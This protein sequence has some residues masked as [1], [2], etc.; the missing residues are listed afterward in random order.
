LQRLPP[1]V[2]RQ[3]H[4]GF[5]ESP[6][7]PQS[8]LHALQSRSFCGG[9]LR[10]RGDGAGVA[11]LGA[12][13]G[14]EALGGAGWVGGASLIGAVCVGAPC[15]IGGAV[16][17]GA[18]RA[19]G[20]SRAIDVDSVP[21]LRVAHATTSNA[22]QHDKRATFR[23]GDMS[24]LQRITVARHLTISA[25]S[26][27][28][29]PRTMLLSIV[30][31]GMSV[32]SERPPR[33]SMSSAPRIT[34]V[35]TTRVL[36]VDDDTEVREA[37]ADVLAANGYEAVKA[38]SGN[39]AL[40]LL[41]RDQT[42][43]LVL[44]DVNLPER[45]GFD[46]LRRL[47]ATDRHRDLPV[48]CVSARTAVEDKIA[49]LKLGA[50]D[51]LAKPFDVQELFA[52]MA[53]PLRVKRILERLDRARSA[54]EHLSLT[55]P[56]TG[57][58][59]RRDLEQ[60]LREEIDRSARRTEPLGCLMID[61]DRFKLVNDEFGHS[62]GDA[63]LSEVATVLRASIRSFDV[64][65]RFGGDEFVVLLPGATLEASRHVAE[66]LCDV[67]STLAIPIGSERT[68][69]LSISAGAVSHDP[70]TLEDAHALLDRA[71]AALL[72]A[73][74]TGRNRVVSNA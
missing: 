36:V 44:L 50:V 38:R 17:T 5:C 55:D 70:A 45:D 72:V 28:I 18:S 4:D 58:P 59:N 64:V 19:I 39:E 42:I 73:K 74:R 54:A 61:V 12:G 62:A 49:G 33:E 46:I 66:A 24:S 22:P 27:H 37:L 43:E 34:P 13:G 20:V 47:K 3:L 2:V 1:S 16:T 60:R 15:S 23:I 65:A 63:V 8:P 35:S 57:L 30:K 26:L 48:I 10:V 68:L 14:A 9:G 53:R 29:A 21:V 69:R 56:V 32:I 11:A 7:M 41:D 25:W 71:D 51:Y 52:R 67:I 40:D 31:S 6:W